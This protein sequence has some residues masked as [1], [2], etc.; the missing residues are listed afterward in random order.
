MTIR[1]FACLSLPAA[2]LAVGGCL[3]TRS[4]IEKLTLQLTAFQGE[5]RAQ[6]VRSDS[7][8]RALVQAATQQIAQQFSRELAHVS[9]SVRQV[10]ASLQRLQ[11]DVQLAMHDVRSQ[12]I[13]LQELAGQS[14]KRIQDLKTSVEA[15]ASAQPVAA[16]AVGT[17]PG[18]TG[19][20]GASATPAAPTAPPAATL[21]R[22]AKGQLQAGATGAARDGFQTLL[23]EYPTHALAGEAQFNIADAFAQEGNKLAADSVYALVVAKYPANEYA[24]NALWKRA[25][26]AREAR[27]TVRHRT[28]LQQIVDKYPRSDV[29]LLADDQL[30]ALK[31]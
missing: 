24:P 1:R 10:S 26:L 12:L 14:Q 25:Q 8:T 3:A 19:A 6:Q 2:L 20:A 22:M 29:R 16:P 31:P 11:G 30:R 7:L 27:D 21:F 15:T 4:D 17:P 9:D 23:T 28:L 13:T 5:T 18:S